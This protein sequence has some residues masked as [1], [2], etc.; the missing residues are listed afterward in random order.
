VEV[1]GVD[2]LYADF[3]RTGAIHPNAPLESTDYGTREFGLLDVH[4]ALTNFFEHQPE[5]ASK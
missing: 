3:S 1:S 5:T 2:A 4:G